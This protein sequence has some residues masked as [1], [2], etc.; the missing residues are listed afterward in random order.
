MC[1]LKM[2]KQIHLLEEH[3]YAV[4]HL[5]WENI[6]SKTGITKVPY[7]SLADPMGRIQSINHESLFKTDDPYCPP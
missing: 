1:L 5:R 6:N 4:P 2:C 7:P 3:G